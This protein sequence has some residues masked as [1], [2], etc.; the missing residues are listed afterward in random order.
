MEDKTNEEKAAAVAAAETQQHKSSRKTQQTSS[1]ENRVCVYN[2]LRERKRDRVID[3]TDE[4]K[5]QG[6][7]YNKSLWSIL[8][9]VC[10][11]ALD[12]PGKF[13]ANKRADTPSCKK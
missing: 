8:V 9:C 12:R 11:C 6:E 7:T 13:Y 10:V 2:L 5:R 4:N 3:T 1:L